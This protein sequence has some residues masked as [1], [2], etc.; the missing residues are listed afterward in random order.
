MTST[1]IIRSR[2][3]DIADVTKRHAAL[4][5]SAGHHYVEDVEHL[6]NKIEELEEQ[7]REMKETPDEDTV[8]DGLKAAN[9]GL[10]E[11]NAKLHAEIPRWV[12]VGERLPAIGDMVLI[13]TEEHI[14]AHAGYLLGGFSYGEWSVPTSGGF[15]HTVTHWMPLPAM[16]KEVRND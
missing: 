9:D 16:P 7:I 13:S 14:Y 12:P 5:E 6:L 11:A 3:C 10:W 4:M 2:L 1:G 15:R 8:S